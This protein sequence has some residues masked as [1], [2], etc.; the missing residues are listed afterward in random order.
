MELCKQLEPSDETLLTTEHS[1]EQATQSSEQRK[2]SVKSC[3]SNCKPACTESRASKL[4]SKVLMQL[5]QCVF[6][7]LQIKSSV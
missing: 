1:Y 6:V 7:L 4:K 2:I 3:N 5:Q